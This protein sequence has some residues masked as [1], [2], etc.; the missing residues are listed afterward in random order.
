[1]TEDDLTQIT[2]LV[3]RAKRN[4]A[5]LQKGLGSPAVLSVELQ[6]LRARLEKYGVV[7]SGRAWDFDPGAGGDVA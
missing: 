3:A 5:M 2:G 1:M 7:L 4:Q 6:R